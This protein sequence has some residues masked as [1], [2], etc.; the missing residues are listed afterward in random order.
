MPNCTQ[1]DISPTWKNV[2]HAPAAAGKRAR[3][4]LRARASLPTRIKEGAQRCEREKTRGSLENQPE[5][6]ERERASRWRCYQRARPGI[7]TRAH[8][9][10]LKRDERAAG[11]VYMRS[12]P[13][14]RGRAGA[15]AGPARIPGFKWTVV[16]SALPRASAVKRASAAAEWRRRRY[17]TEIR[18]GIVSR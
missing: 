13:K 1:R 14:V 11:R 17:T 5:N 3:T 9:R 2:T 15:A 8:K 10:I 7:M 4:P 12:R 6:P 16:K 18:A